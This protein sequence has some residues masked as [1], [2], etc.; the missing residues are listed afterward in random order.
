MSEAMQRLKAKAMR[1]R[2]A[3]VTST[4]AMIL[5]GLAFAAGPASADSGTCPMAST[6]LSGVGT[7]GDPYLISTGADLQLFRN[8]SNSSP[9]A[10]GT[11][12]R[13]TSNIDLTG[14]TWSD[15]IAKTTYFQGVYNGGGFEISGL[16]INSANSEVGLFGRFGY[17]S[18][19]TI[20]NLGFTGT[21]AAT[22]ATARAGGLVGN[23]RSGTIENSYSTSRVSSLGPQVGGLVG[24]AFLDVGSLTISNSFFTGSVSTTAAGGSPSGAGGLVG[25]FVADGFN[26]LTVINSYSTGLVTATASPTGGLLGDSVSASQ[27]MVIESF[28]DTITSGQATTNRSGTGKTTAEMQLLGTYSPWSIGAGFDSGKTWGICSAVNSGYPFLTAFYSLDP[29]IGEIVI[30]AALWTN[31]F[32]SLPLPASGLCEDITQEQNTFAGYGTDTSGS[33][34]K[35]WQPW[36]NEKLSDS[37]ERI[38]G[39]ACWRNLTNTG[40][41]R[42]VASN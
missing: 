40:G 4:T 1:R 14:C 34:V 33:W 39:W 2:I 13:Q 16:T 10:A 42:W 19:G 6:S 8:T 30:D 3:V 20:K 18:R 35:G 26:R 25:Y 36:V 28:W 7:S 17:L 21:V 27:L 24:S 22:G 31:Y 23:A 38:G 9:Y 15:P 11:E 29:C 41:T 32:Q 37:G 12:F 5:V